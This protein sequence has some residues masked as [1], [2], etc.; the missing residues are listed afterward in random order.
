MLVWVVMRMRLR[1]G[2]IFE[3]STAGFAVVSATVLS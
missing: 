1:T 2:D 3:L